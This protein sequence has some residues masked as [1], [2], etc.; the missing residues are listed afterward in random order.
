MTTTRFFYDPLVAT[1]AE[2]P[3]I[4]ALM[5]KQGVNSDT[6][7]SV[8]IPQI[9]I[10]EK[11][12]EPITATESTPV[13]TTT[14]TPQAEAAILETPPQPQEP[15][16][17]PPV[18]IEPVQPKAPT[19]QEVLRQHQ[20][21]AI[22]KELGYDEKLVGFKELDPKMIAFFNRWQESKGD[23]A[24]YLR[25]LITDYDKLSSEEVMRHQLRRDYPKATEKQLEI[26]F[27]KN[28]VHAYGLDTDD[29]DALENGRALLEVE[30]DRFRET[31]KS[32]QQ[33]YL[34]PKP[35]EPKA[36]EVDLSAQR[37]QQEYDSYKASVSDNRMT[38]DIVASKTFTIGE[39]DE[40]FSFPINPEAVTGLLFDS[41][42]WAAKM[43]HED[44]KPKT[45]HQLL[46]AMVTEYGEDFLKE[47]AKHYKSLGSKAIVAPLENA[48]P[49][50]QTTNTPTAPAFTSI[51]EAM[52]KQGRVS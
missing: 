37:A 11:T 52:A 41:Q 12:E 44:G 20:P 3:S 9:S 18:Q 26:L 40:K 49:V 4:A 35:P 32:K 10:T 50:S 21:E 6:G 42:K 29:A 14:E 23:V 22:F 36:P 17:V 51:A 25:E 15:V 24:D 43:F 16:I 45:E 2:Q 19:L 31:L 47:Y 46:V 39:G 28:V 30:A 38:R 27:N 5:A 34:L 13:A 1:S 33:E 7:N 48:S 8:A